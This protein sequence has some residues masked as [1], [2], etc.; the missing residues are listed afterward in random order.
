M[1][2][3][4]WDADITT[5]WE[6]KKDDL[7]DYDYCGN[8]T[9]EQTGT[10]GQVDFTVRQDK[11]NPDYSDVYTKKPD[12]THT[13][14]IIDKNGNLVKNCHDYRAELISLRDSLLAL[15]EFNGKVKKLTR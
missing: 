4:P 15:E 11:N 14:D 8:R 2:K 13:H 12:G 5:A 7:S 9:Y 10:Y 1:G 3:E 6:S